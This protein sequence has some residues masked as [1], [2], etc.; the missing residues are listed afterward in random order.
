M[1]HAGTEFPKQAP[2]YLGSE[3]KWKC[4]QNFTDLVDDHAG[5][6]STIAVGCGRGPHKPDEQ[7]VS[8]KYPAKAAG[9]GSAGI[10]NPR[11]QNLLSEIDPLTFSFCLLVHREVLQSWHYLCLNRPEH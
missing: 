3:T 7:R 5:I 9:D 11:L 8:T 10:S 2:D 1:E 4:G 6:K